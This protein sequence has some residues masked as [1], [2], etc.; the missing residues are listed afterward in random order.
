MTEI[1]QQP[2]R[3]RPRLNA[4]LSVSLREFARR[5]A[6][7]EGVAVDLLVAE[8]LEREG[9]WPPPDEPQ[10]ASTGPR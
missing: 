8:G 2:P 1:V 3:V 4:R 7:P 10:E 5:K 6:L 9:L